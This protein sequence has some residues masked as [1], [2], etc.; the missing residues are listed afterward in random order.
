ML[1]ITAFIGRFHPVLVHLPIGIL[2]TGLLL[3]ALSR[4]PKYALPTAAVKVIWC[5]GMLSALFSCLTGYLLSIDGDYDPSLVNTHMWMGFSVLA[6]SGLLFVKSLKQEKGRVYTASTIGL[7]LLIVVTGHLGGSLTHGPDYLTAS[8]KGPKA[9]IAARRPIPDIREAVV[10]AD[11]IQPMLQ[12]HCYSCHGP[13]RQK[14]GL[15]LDDSASIMKG[16]KDGLVLHASGPA[17][18]E[19][20]ERL[21]LPAEEDHHMPP[22]SKPSLKESE[23]AL[24]Q[25]WVAQG[26]SFS[27][28]VKDLPQTAVAATF[29]LALQTGKNSGK[30][31]LKIPPLLPVDPVEPAPEKDIEAL[32]AR[33]VLV[34]P[35]AKNS[36]YLSVNFV[37]A[38][39]I[40]DKDMA[41]LLPLRRQLLW[42]RLGD[43]PIGDS[44]MTT[45]ASCKAL[46]VLHLNNTLIGD[47]GFTQLASLPELRF[48][49]LCGTNITAEGVRSLQR[50]KHLRSVFLYRT[51]CSS[52]DYLSLKKNFQDV[53]LD[54]GGYSVPFAAWDTINELRH[55]K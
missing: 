7:T 12:V 23:I 44:A 5:A 33:Q 35:I 30:D 45:I 27:K 26:A 29:L 10:Y 2:L 42:L 1:S 49:N 4:Y 37:N 31:D 34:I 25:W 6:L 53:S 16:G 40:T 52:S 54:T 18:S 55:G 15:R 51:K 9:V 32:K 39:G 3:E 50:L 43:Q 47:R 36:H 11:I 24:F 17:E 48:L 19:L 46:T 38:V 28:K 20:I 21:L 14:G 13:D 41:L 22:R 8:F